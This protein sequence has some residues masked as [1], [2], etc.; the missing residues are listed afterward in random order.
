MDRVHGE[1]EFEMFDEA[2][3]A[4]IGAFSHIHEQLN[5]SQRGIVIDANHKKVLVTSGDVICDLI[6][7]NIVMKMIYPIT[8]NNE[9]V[10]VVYQ[11]FSTRFTRL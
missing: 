2:I 1:L 6:H 8:G 3:S 11:P 4:N 7:G 9:N 5:L 10:V